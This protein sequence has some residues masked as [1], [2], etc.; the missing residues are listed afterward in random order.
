LGRLH[1]LE[2]RKLVSLLLETADDFANET[3][4]DA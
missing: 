1:E 3:S 4:F 2:A